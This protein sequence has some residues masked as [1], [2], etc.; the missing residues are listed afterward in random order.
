MQFREFESWYYLKRI[1]MVDTQ[2]CEDAR[3]YA[4]G[5]LEQK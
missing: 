5:C 4:Q 1:I 3:S 2:L